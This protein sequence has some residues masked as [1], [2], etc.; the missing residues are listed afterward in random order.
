MDAKDASASGAR[1]RKIRYRC[2]LSLDVAA[3]L[4]GVTKDD[5]SPSSG[6]TSGIRGESS[7]R[8]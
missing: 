5:S 4:T 3:G 7:M 2:G 6:D 1:A 8:E